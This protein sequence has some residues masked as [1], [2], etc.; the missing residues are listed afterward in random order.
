MLMS[1][2]RAQSSTVELT[3]IHNYY[4]KHVT[5]SVMNSHPR[6]LKDSDFLADTCCVALNHLPPRYIRHD[7]D[8]NFFMSPIEREEMSKKVQQAVDNAIKLVLAHEQE[9]HEQSD[10]NTSN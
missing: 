8:M 1:R 6:A 3:T 4:E 9:K 10:T 5:E 7:V 2:P